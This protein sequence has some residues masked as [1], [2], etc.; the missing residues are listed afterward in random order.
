MVLLFFIIG[1]DKARW[2]TN[3]LSEDF[4][5]DLTSTPFHSAPL[6]GFGVGLPKTESPWWN[7]MSIFPP[8]LIWLELW[9]LARKCRFPLSTYAA[10]IFFIFFFLAARPWTPPATGNRSNNKNRK[11]DLI[12]VSCRWLFGL[13]GQIS[14]FFL[15]FSHAETPPVSS[16]HPTSP[17]SS[18]APSAV[19]T[20]SW[21]EAF[22]TVEAARRAART[23]HITLSSAAGRGEGHLS[24]RLWV[25]T[26]VCEWGLQCARETRDQTASGEAGRQLLPS[27]TFWFLETLLVFPPLTV[28]KITA[29]CGW[30]KT[31]KKS[32]P[33]GFWEETAQWIRMLWTTSTQTWTLYPLVHRQS[34]NIFHVFIKWDYFSLLCLVNIKQLV[35]ISFR[36]IRGGRRLL[37]RYWVTLPMCVILVLVTFSHNG[38]LILLPRGA[39]CAES[40]LAWASLSQRE[41]KK[42]T[43]TSNFK[44]WWLCNM[45]W[46]L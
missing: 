29:V 41:K 37:L 39:S 23:C 40:W 45:S 8:H 38:R 35:F 36:G 17:L 34:K 16:S 1:A 2:W 27:P 11:V 44:T 25:R 33:S 43:S 31:N 22:S 18:Q 24:Q 20:L 26:P 42:L 15:L 32:S 4:R 30:K 3:S 21:S 14:T 7:I 19:V 46:L 6:S 10:W 5:C 13:A 9:A 28:K 12:P